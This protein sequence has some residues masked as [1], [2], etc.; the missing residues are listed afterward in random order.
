MITL[1]GYKTGRLPGHSVETVCQVLPEAGC[2]LQSGETAVADNLSRA[3]EVERATEQAG[4]H[5][6]AKPRLM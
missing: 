4:I 1:G 3:M 5:W 2:F 6:Q